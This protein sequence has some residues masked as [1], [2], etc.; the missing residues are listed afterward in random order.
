MNSLSLSFPDTI[1]ALKELQK[2]ALFEYDSDAIY[3]KEP[4]QVGTNVN[5]PVLCT[6][7]DHISTTEKGLMMNVIYNEQPSTIYDKD[8]E[9]AFVIF[10]DHQNFHP[11]FTERSEAENLHIYPNALQLVLA[12]LQDS[13]KEW[14]LYQ[15][16]LRMKA[17]HYHRWAVNPKR[18]K[19]DKLSW[20]ERLE[21]Q[22]LS[23]EVDHL[24]WNRYGKND[25]ATLNEMLTLGEEAYDVELSKINKMASE[26][27]DELMKELE[28]EKKGNQSID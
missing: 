27:L 10:E 7:I 26:V 2:I 4:V 3:L 20:E 9:F 1:K 13:G 16:E 19:E 22:R 25:Q 15:R 21:W 14:I 6:Y 24:S 17:R 23:V 11:T 12:A 28:E 18:K 5:G 8:Y